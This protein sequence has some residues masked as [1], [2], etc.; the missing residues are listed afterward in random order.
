MQ[1]ISAS[2]AVVG[3]ALLAGC[4][5]VDI[6]ESEPGPI[7]PVAE[8]YSPLPA[9]TR[10]PESLAKSTPR[11]SPDAT[12]IMSAVPDRLQAVDDAGCILSVQQ[13]EAVTGMQF[14]EALPVKYGYSEDRASSY[15]GDGL[16]Y[17]QLYTVRADSGFAR[18]IRQGHMNRYQD[19]ENMEIPR[20]T[21]ATLFND[22]RWLQ[23][24]VGENYV[25]VEVYLDQ[26]PTPLVLDVATAVAEELTNSS[27]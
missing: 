9:P 25:M 21:D 23:M 5:H 20:A 8:S 15:L 19:A 10:E 26:Y 24:V 13:M 11:S 27:S 3:V 7:G 17:V 16:M 6:V 4:A 1:A 12:P 14:E 2:L 22:Q 18:Q